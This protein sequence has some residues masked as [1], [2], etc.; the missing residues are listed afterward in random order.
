LE[1]C[2]K[3]TLLAIVRSEIGSPSINL[4]YLTDFF[5]ANLELEANEIGESMG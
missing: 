4:D 3:N 1:A 2:G 5:P